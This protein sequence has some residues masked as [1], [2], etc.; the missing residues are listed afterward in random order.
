M[1]A[2]LMHMSNFAPQQARFPSL[3]LTRLGGTVLAGTVPHLM[4]FGLDFKLE[5]PGD[6]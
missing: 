4:M 2:V 1:L 5:C 6:T 3:S